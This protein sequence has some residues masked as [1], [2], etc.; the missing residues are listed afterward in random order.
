M[1]DRTCPG[2]CCET[3][4]LPGTLDDLA[5]MADTIIDGPQI[6]AMLEPIGQQTGISHHYRCRNWDPDTQL[7]RDYENRPFMCRDY[8][9]GQACEHCGL[10]DGIPP[11]ERLALE[12]Q[13]A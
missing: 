5:K 12:R 1:P 4:F 8:P 10:V 3:V 9:Y 7:C 2:Y 6:F 11:T 13:E